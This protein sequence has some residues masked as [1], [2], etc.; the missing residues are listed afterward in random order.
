[1][2]EEV[3]DFCNGRESWGVGPVRACERCGKVFCKEC[4]SRLHSETE[5]YNMMS[6]GYGIMC[7]DCYKGYKYQGYY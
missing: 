5:Y 3:C 6:S 7:P 1:M 4:F 2:G